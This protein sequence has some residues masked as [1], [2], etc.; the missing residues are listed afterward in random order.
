M[1]WTQ[2]DEHFVDDV[3]ILDLCDPQVMQIDPQRQLVARI[4]QLLSNGRTKIVL[5]LR[6]LGYI[7]SD[8]LGQIVDAYKSGREAGGSVKLCGLTPQLRKLLGATRLDSF[9]EG[10][11]SEQD[12]VQ[13]FSARF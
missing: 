10:F 1:R 3:V 9:L 11:D 4:R 2:I 7:D 8:G 12:A 13:S 5:N 6:E